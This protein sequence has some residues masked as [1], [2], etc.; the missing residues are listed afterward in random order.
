MKQLIVFCEGP[1]EQG[2]CAQVLRPYLFPQHDGTIHTLAVGSKNDHHVYGI[3]EYPRLKKFITNMLN[4]YPTRSVRFTTLIDL[5]ALPPEFP[6]KAENTRNPN[7][8]SPYVL[9]LETAF[10]RDIDDYRFIPHLQLHEYESMLFTDPEAF[11]IAFENCNSEIQK[12][13]EIAASFP[14]IEHINDGRDTAPSKRIINL[15]PAYAGRKASAG[16]DIAEFVGITRIRA[17][18]PHFNQWLS[19]LDAVY[20]SGL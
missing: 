14:S 15:L 1:T 17:A 20:G 5:Y 7:D 2:F 13:K 9:A 8:P 10:G 4:R 6:G 3:S 19:R 11:T 18:C 12:L 16:P